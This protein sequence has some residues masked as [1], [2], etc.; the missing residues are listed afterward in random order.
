[1]ARA[2][3]L[4]GL[5]INEIKWTDAGGAAGS[6]SAES[7]YMDLWVNLSSR[8][9][10]AQLSEWGAISPK[11]GTP[12]QSVDTMK[13]EAMALAVE[14]ITDGCKQF[15]PSMMVKV[16]DFVVANCP[17]NNWEYV[18]FLGWCGSM[19]ESWL[20]YMDDTEGT[21]TPQR[22]VMEQFDMTFKVVKRSIVDIEQTRLFESELTGQ[23]AMAYGIL[24][25]AIISNQPDILSEPTLAGMFADFI[26]TT[27]AM[28]SEY[29]ARKEKAFSDSLDLPEEFLKNL[30][31]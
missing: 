4:D 26:A 22:I 18:K 16:K 14:I 23:T 27:K 3:N 11:A 21:E 5:D 2:L 13:L 12:D 30:K 28:Q 20:G 29:L 15:P 19:L 1:M 25:A 24:K 31:F 7:G 6:L 8:T 17:P 10:S 9:A